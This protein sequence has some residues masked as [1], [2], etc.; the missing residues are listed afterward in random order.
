MTN[1]MDDAQRELEYWGDVHY[2]ELMAEAELIAQGHAEKLL[3]SFASGDHGR[4]EREKLC[5][6]LDDDAK[7]QELDLGY[8]VKAARYK[9]QPTSIVIRRRKRDKLAS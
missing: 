4:E 1:D 2:P 9:N 8:W 5:G 6:R 3:V 7:F